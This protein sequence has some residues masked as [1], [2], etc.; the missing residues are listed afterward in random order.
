MS[1]DVYGDVRF[2]RGKIG[3]FDGSVDL[4]VGVGGVYTEDDCAAIQAEANPACAETAN[5]LHPAS[6]LG[7]A[8]SVGRGQWGLRLRGERWQYTEVIVGE[9]DEKRIP[10][11]FG[12]DVV[13]R[14][15]GG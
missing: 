10:V 7:L 14:L 12:A 15:G 2:A 11:W 8:A 9:V 4:L 3:P 5:Q 6:V 13:F 1:A